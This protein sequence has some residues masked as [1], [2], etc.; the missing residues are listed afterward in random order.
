M[1]RIF[2]TISSALLLSGSII[3]AQAPANRTVQTIVADVLAQLPAEDQDIY[4]ELME[5]LCTAGED[6]VLALIGQM[7]LP[8]KGSNARIEYALSGMSHFVTAADRVAARSMLENAY[9]KALEQQEDREIK[10]FIIR[11]TGICGTDAGIDKLA[12]YLNSEDLSGPA[13]RA[14]ASIGSEKAGRALTASLM[15]RMGTPKTQQDVILALSKIPANGAEELVKG[16]LNSDHADIRKVALYTLSKI[17]TKASLPEVLTAAEKAGFTMDR[18]GANDACILLIKR[19]LEQ[20]D[21]KEAVTAANNLFKK[22]AKAD[23]TATRIAALQLLMTA[24]D[25]KTA[26]KTL[27]TALKDPCREYRNAALDAASAFADKTLYTGLLKSAGKMNT[28]QQIDIISWISREAQCPQKRGILNTVEVAIEKTGIQS[29][30]E[31]LGKSN[32]LDLKQAIAETL[33]NLNNAQVIPA[34]ANLLASSDKDV[35]ALGKESL[36]VCK[37]DVT[38]A[39]AKIM[40]SAGDP[41]KMAGAELLAMRRATNLLNV[42]LELINSGSTEVKETAYTALKDVV[43]EKDI[44]NLCGM[45]ESA[46]EEPSVI[47]SIQ[48]ALVASMA[49]LSASRQ[50]ETITRRMIQAGESKKH[51]YYRPLSATGESKALDMIVD[52]FGNGKGEAKDAA[53]DALTNWKGVEVMDILYAIA[54]DP[55]SSTYAG[56][57]LDSYIK[58]ASDPGLTGENRLIYLRNA[59]EI[60]RTDA[61]KNVILEQTG[62]TG[63]YLGLLYAGEFIDQPALK[64]NASVAVMTIALAHREYTGDLVINLLNR[65]AAAL[66]NPDADYQ[67]QSIRL[68][69]EE[70]PEEKGF[71]SLF[72]GKDLTGWKGLVQNPVARAKMTPAQLAK[73]QAKADEQ[74]R[75]DWKVQDGLLVF[76]GT[77]YDNLCTEKQ[78]GD[79]EMYV[80]WKLDPA[81]TEADAGIY[82]RGTP[83]VQMWDTARVKVGAQV[84]SGGLYNN[85]THESKPLKVADNKLGEWNTMYI[86]M[87]GD[88]VTVK[89]NGELV[90]DDVILENFWDRKQPLFPTE[91]IELQAHGSKV[92]YRNLYVKELERPEPYQLTSEEV[93]EGYK[94]LFD[95]THMHEWSGNLV[96]YSI[97]NGTISLNPDKNS[98]GN[99]YTKNEY[100]DFIFRFEFQLTPA[101]N[102]GLGIRMPTEG[103]AA[104]A[105]MEL[106]ILDN[107]H[108]VYSKLQAYQYHGSVYGII[109]AKR[110]YLKPVGEW[111]YQEVEAKGNRIKVT[112]NGTVILD[113]DIEEAIKNSTPDG[114][115]HPGLFNKKG[116]IG[117]LGHGSPVK[118]RNI[119]IK[120]L[121]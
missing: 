54:K 76:D 86:K 110:G 74:M 115:E 49:S 23:Q 12:V 97:E 63:T 37:G 58:L 96:D 30:V 107:E 60:A 85:Q 45:L 46:K 18:S 22:S 9:Y 98:G 91:Q 44:T 48:Q 121:K 105:G 93:K 111:N 95:G 99:L 108:P 84:G 104:Y 94:I 103:D 87:A 68:L 7:N 19:V 61:Q 106:Q 100:G 24:Q 13:S 10:A 120:E 42:V 55:A 40:A 26:S 3:T 114:K 2:L 102:N 5:D 43:G 14:I 31:L 118:F 28:S 32:D 92:Y 90:T 6:G 29:L 113:G 35:V 78:Y 53:F 83:Q 80:D 89:L 101:A 62:L 1:K 70:M 4:D 79:I 20:G 11:Q 51:L 72:N 117:F 66:S 15:R 116:R 50:V 88:R 8:G 119:R 109:P 64:E 57:A 77:G 59:M 81:G 41:G 71:V 36:A 34:L 56:K 47:V 16:Y 112:L 38:A 75:K 52:G 73:A 27:M 21:T 67:R 69:L 33:V 82:L 65:A 25:D 39:V 17:G